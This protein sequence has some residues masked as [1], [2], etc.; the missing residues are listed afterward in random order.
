MYAIRIIH[1]DTL[2][3][4]EYIGMY[5]TDLDKIRT[6]FR[7]MAQGD[8]EGKLHALELISLKMD[9][10]TRS[11]NEWHIAET[12]ESREFDDEK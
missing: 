8:V 6:K 4:T 9:V 2:G 11:A 5:S 1:S 12:L 10:L 3:Y 7:S